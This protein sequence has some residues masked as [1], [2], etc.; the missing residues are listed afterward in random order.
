MKRETKLFDYNYDIVCKT[1]YLADNLVDDDYAK[2]FE[3]KCINVLNK[4]CCGNGGTT[5]FVDYAK[6]HFKGLLV[7]VPNVSICKSKEVQY[8]GS[9]DV[10]II[11]SLS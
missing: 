8:E 7:L 10:W 5:G 9:D 6:K 11:C 2:W 1:F 3:S 4:T